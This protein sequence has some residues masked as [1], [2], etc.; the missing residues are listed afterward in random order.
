MSPMIHRTRSENSVSV[1]WKDLRAGQKIKLVVTS[2]VIHKEKVDAYLKKE[3]ELRE[4]LKRAKQASREKKL[5]YSFGSLFGQ[6][7]IKQSSKNLSM[8]FIK[9]NTN[10]KY[11]TKSKYWLTGSVSLA[12]F[13]SINHT[14]SSKTSSSGV[15]PEFGF[16][17]GRSLGKIYLTLGYDMLNYYLASSLEGSISLKSVFS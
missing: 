17:I 13:L 12:K 5:K 2:D 3:K 11:Q 4:E 14:D 7:K 8:S 15:V 6:V 1:N 16:G 10:I 9:L